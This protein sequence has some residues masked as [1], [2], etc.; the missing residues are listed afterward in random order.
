MKLKTAKEFI[1]TEKETIIE[2]GGPEVWLVV[3]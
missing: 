3:L 1:S 2:L